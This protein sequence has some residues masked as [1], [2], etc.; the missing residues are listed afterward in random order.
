MILIGLA[1][2]NIQRVDDLYPIVYL[3]NDDAS[4]EIIPPPSSNDESVEQWA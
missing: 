2:A 3:F 4:C 1:F